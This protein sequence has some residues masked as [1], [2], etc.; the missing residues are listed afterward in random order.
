MATLVATSEAVVVISQ[1]CDIVRDAKTRP[2]VTVAQLVRLTDPARTEA[3][4]GSPAEIR[5]GAGGG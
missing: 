4:R 1:T 3:G 5:R 2:F